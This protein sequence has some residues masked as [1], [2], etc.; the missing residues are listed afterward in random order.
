LSKQRKN[1]DDKT[2]NWSNFLMELLEEVLLSNRVVQAIMTKLQHSHHL[3][4]KT[5]DSGFVL[6]L[7]YF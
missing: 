1:F 5:E 6:P 7:P 3:V 2:K 4:G